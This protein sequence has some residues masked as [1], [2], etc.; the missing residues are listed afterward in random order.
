V[1]YDAVGNMTVCPQ[2]GAWTTSLSLKYDAWNRLVEVKQGSTVLGSYQYDGLTRRTT[3]TIG[4]DVR[5]F[6]YS[7]QWQIL[8]ERLGSTV[9]RQ[10]VW[11]QRYVDD[12]VL[13]DR[14]TGSSSSYNERIYVLHDYFHPTT[15]MDDSGTILERIGYDAYGTSR[16]MNANFGTSSPAPTDYEWET[17]FAGY[18]WDSESALYQVRNRSLNPSVGK[19]TTRDPAGESEGTNLNIYTKGSPLSTVDPFGDSISKADCD[20]A[21]SKAQNTNSTVQKIIK[22]ITKYME[23]PP[24]QISCGDCCN[25]PNE[26]CT[27]KGSTFCWAIHTKNGPHCPA[28]KKTRQKHKQ[29]DI[30]ICTDGP[31]RTSEEVINTVIHEYYHAYICCKQGSSQSCDDAICNEIGAYSLE[32]PTADVQTIILD[33]VGS[34]YSVNKKCR[35][36]TKH[37]IAV[38]AKEKYVECVDDALLLLE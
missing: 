21:V 7:D 34:V 4:T 33:V 19:W 1:D 5:H 24:P 38:R 26:M 35:H 32:D 29:A 3:K 16:L 20:A 12:L 30:T 15:L 25:P 23:C 6:Y 9:Q 11:G 18:R 27:T 8:E 10:F 37:E 28:C 14:K 22:I 2:P 13:R 17:R 31:N 36:L